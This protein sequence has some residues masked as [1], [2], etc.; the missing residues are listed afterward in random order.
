MSEEHTEDLVD[1]RSFEE[2]V[3]ARFDALDSRFDAVEL[4]LNSLELRFDAMES[5]PDAMDSRLLKL[6]VVSERRSLETK[7]ISE[8][9]LA[10]IEE[11]QREFADFRVEVRE[12]FRDVSRKFGVLASDMIQLRA[13]QTHIETRRDM[14]ESKFSG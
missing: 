1:R 11:L 5:R 4:R 3:F 10:R 6:E 13:N 2:R 9:V 14:L 7:P 12:A 8:R